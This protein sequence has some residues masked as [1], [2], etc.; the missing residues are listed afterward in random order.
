MIRILVGALLARGV[1][2]AFVQLRE[3][4]PS[5][6][7]NMLSIVQAGTCLTSNQLDFD[8]EVAFEAVHKI[9]ELREA[10]R[11]TFNQ[12]VR[13]LGLGTVPGADS[14]H[15]SSGRPGR[16]AV[17]AGHQNQRGLSSADAGK[18]AQ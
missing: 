17:G 15:G 13:R 9:H 7:H 10:D 6:Y 12:V 11:T 3:D 18:N 1:R 8:E 16:G 2:R 5:W 4:R 14:G